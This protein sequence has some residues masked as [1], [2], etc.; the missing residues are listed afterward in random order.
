MM[1]EKGVWWSLQPFLD[2]E[3]AIPVFGKVRRAPGEEEQ[4]EIDRGDGH[5]PTGT[6]EAVQG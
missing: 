5:R 1:A 3:D 4:I 6:G 2:D